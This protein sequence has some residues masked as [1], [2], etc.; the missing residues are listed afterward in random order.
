MVSL[1]MLIFTFQII[2][3]WFFVTAKQ[4]YMENSANIK[5]D[6]LME[7]HLYFLTSLTKID[8]SKY[9]NWLEKVNI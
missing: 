6:F 5:P 2:D 4:E 8:L 3:L 9:M 1:T 7:T